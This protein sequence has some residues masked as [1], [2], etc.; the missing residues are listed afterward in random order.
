MMIETIV[1][2]NISTTSL[3]LFTLKGLKLKPTHF[4]SHINKYSTPSRERG[5]WTN[6]FIRR[7]RD[8]GYS[9]TTRGGI[10]R[11]HI[12]PKSK[13]QC[14]SLFLTQNINF[15]WDHAIPL[16]FSFS[17]FYND[18]SHGFCLLAAPQHKNFHIRLSINTTTLL[19]HYVAEGESH[20]S[21]L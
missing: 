14:S 18:G 6:S 16:D 10:Q 2:I 20:N 4:A 5:F 3:F 12:D 7:R 8:F 17:G 13:L 1:F 15:I 11:D 21:F 9:T 19:M